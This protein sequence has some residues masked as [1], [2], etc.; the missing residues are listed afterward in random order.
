[1][2]MKEELVRTDEENERHRQQV[3]LNRKRRNILKQQLLEIKQLS[4]PPVRNSSKSM[5]KVNNKSIIFF[6]AIVGS[7]HIFSR[8]SHLVS[9]LFF[10][11]GYFQ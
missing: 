4:I 7:Y 9:I 11:L 1:M 5:R 6:N 10:L 8:F 3:N 2:G